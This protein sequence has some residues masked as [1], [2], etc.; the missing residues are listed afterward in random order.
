LNTSERAKNIAAPTVFIGAYDY[1]GAKTSGLSAS[2]ILY[3]KLVPAGEDLDFQGTGGSGN[4]PG[5]MSSTN[6]TKTAIG[7][8]FVA[9]TPYYFNGYLGEFIAYNRLLTDSEIVTLNNYLAK[10]WG[11]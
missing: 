4:G 8:R 11:L 3:D 6:S 9:S 1:V 5:Y 7:R 2:I 10:K